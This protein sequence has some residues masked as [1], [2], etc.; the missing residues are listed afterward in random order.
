[1]ATSLL[2]DHGWE[3]WQRFE[4]CFGSVAGVYGASQGLWDRADTTEYREIAQ[5]ASGSGFY[6]QVNVMV[7]SFGGNDI[8]FSDVIEGCIV[9]HLCDES[10]D[11]LLNR[12]KGLGQ[13][14]PD[15]YASVVRDRLAESGK[16]Y[17]IGYPSLVAP[18]GEWPSF[19]KFGITIIPTCERISWRNGVM[20]YDVA[21][22]L[23]EQMKAAVRKA[24]SEFPETRIYYLDTLTLYRTGRVNGV[25]YDGTANGK[26]ELCTSSSGEEEAA[27]SARWINGI[28]WRLTQ[29]YLSVRLDVDTLKSQS[30]HPNGYGHSATGRALADLIRSTFEY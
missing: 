12:V 11:E 3:F 16:L 27:D 25:D 2:S 22:E 19:S 1:M 9:N 21:N 30:F 20:L 18:V 17:V 6:S 15:F 26:H 14:L 8:G 5:D 29:S 7:M 28:V 13:S 23:N 10:E 24:N 4:A